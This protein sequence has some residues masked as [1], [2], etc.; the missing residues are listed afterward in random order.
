ML[1]LPDLQW[2]EFLVVKS[3]RVG[4]G[5]LSGVYLLRHKPTG[6]IYVGSTSISFWRRLVSH[7]NSWFISSNGGMAEFEFAILGIISNRGLL[8]QEEN[9]WIQSLNAHDPNVGF[10]I[11]GY[12]C[13][14]KHR[15]Q[16]F[17]R[18]LNELAKK[19][20]RGVERRQ[21]ASRLLYLAV[22][23][24]SRCQKPVGRKVG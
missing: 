15:R 4:N 17:S 11:V 21:R 18:S 16:R 2:S 8:K 19:C 5:T 10:N 23:E 3:D 1:R 22:D 7:R 12:S 9:N 24:L 6:K 14:P 13:Q 20:R